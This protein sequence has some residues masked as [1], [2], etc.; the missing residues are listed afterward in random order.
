MPQKLITQTN[1]NDEWQVAPAEWE[2]SSY[3]SHKIEYRE[4]VKKYIQ[5]LNNKSIRKKAFFTISTNVL[6]ADIDSSKVYNGSFDRDIY[7]PLEISITKWTF[8]HG[9]EP[10][11]ERVLESKVWMI[12]P[13]R[14]LSA[15][16]AL[17]HKAK[18]KI[19]LDPEDTDNEYVQKDLN[20]VIKEINSFL[21]ADRLVFS[22]NIKHIRQDLGCL[23]WLNRETE[24]KLK[25]IKVFSLEDL[26]IVVVRHLKPGQEGISSGPVSHRLEHASDTYNTK[27]HCSYHQAKSNIPDSDTCYCAKGIS[28]T[29]SNVIIDDVKI[30]ADLM[31]IKP[32]QPVT[33]DQES[34]DLSENINQLK[35]LS[36]NNQ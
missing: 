22:I 21:S 23:K 17:D 2:L 6:C 13:G 5:P 15:S 8:K 26:Y 9:N 34:D 18:H 1:T 27:L 28:L 7:Q 10:V 35:S 12:N 31:D 3:D 30:V 25:P 11:D 14:P 19:D 24:W 16:W 4:H 33:V 20:K 32:L 36:I 29:Y